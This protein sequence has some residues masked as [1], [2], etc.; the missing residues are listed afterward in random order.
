MEPAQSP[1]DAVD[2]IVGQWRRERPD[3]DLDSMAI[4]GRIHRVSEL[5]RRRLKSVF[6]PFG[7]GLSEFDVVATLRRSGEPFELSPK[8]LS[9]TLMLTSGGLTGR[10][11]KL[12]R[13][14][15]IERRPD[16]SDRRGLRIRLT[17]AGWR[18]ADEAVTAEIDELARV[19]SSALSPAEART[20]G[21]LLR[22]LHGPYAGDSLD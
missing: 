4:F 21:E 19:L 16:P 10:L 14:G 12:E 22:K 20:L 11:D 2:A 7:I 5:S 13:A 17:E 9:R 15:L 18:A 8:E 6:A 1:A 3:L